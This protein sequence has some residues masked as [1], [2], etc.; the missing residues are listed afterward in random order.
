MLNIVT[1]LGADY[2]MHLVF[3]SGSEIAGGKS[4]DA[5]SAGLAWLG[6]K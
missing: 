5:F 3:G 2:G 1:D 4:T 6:G